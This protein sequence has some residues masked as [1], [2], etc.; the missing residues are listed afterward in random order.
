SSFEKYMIRHRESFTKEQFARR[1][2]YGQIV[3]PAYYEKYIHSW[4]KIV[5]IEKIIS[6]VAIEGVPAKGKL[7][8][9]EFDG[10]MVNV[11]DYK[12]GNPDNAKTKIKGPSEKDPLGGDYWRQAVFYKLL[13][14][15]SPFGWQVV[16]TE[17]DFIEPD[18]KKNYKKEKI[19]ISPEDEAFVIRQ[20]TET[21]EKIRN[22]DFYTGCG[23]EDCHWCNFVKTN[24][25]DINAPIAEE[26]EE[27]QSL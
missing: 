4:N 26:E 20:I 3:L 8:K 22:H 19:F 25:L 15:R 12:T 18:S 2:E 21:W 24:K 1:M 23:K 11:V 27:H 13:V 10:K 7:D 9:L 17:F 5:S 16:S 14:D 6:N